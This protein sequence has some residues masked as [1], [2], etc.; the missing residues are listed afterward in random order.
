ML[1][2][3]KD[4]VVAQSPARPPAISTGAPR[5]VQQRSLDVQRRILDA[6]VEVLIAHGDA[7]AATTRS[8]ERAGVARGRLRHHFPSR[9]ALLVAA[10]HHL[11]VGRV[12][13]M[14]DDSDW[15]TEPGPRIDRAVDALA[16]SFTENYF[17]AATEL[18]IA[19]RNHAEIRASLLEPESHI[20]RSYRASMDRLFG[21]ELSSRDRYEDLREVLFTSLRGMALTTA[22]DPR[23]DPSRRHTERLKRLARTLLL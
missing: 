8:Q 4:V 13:A 21:P 5:P 1:L 2:E 9:D 23:Q 12:A 7:G 22:F 20:A 14:V 16:E 18:W 10:S 19:A 6:A 3:R 17:W 15:P 11:S